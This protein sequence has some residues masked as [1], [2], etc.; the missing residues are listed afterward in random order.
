MTPVPAGRIA[1]VVTSLEMRQPPRPRPVPASELRLVR[2]PSPALDAYRTLFRRVGEPWLWFSRLIMPD[3]Q[4]AAIVGDARV[5]IHAVVDRRGIEVGML[6]LDFRKPGQCELAFFGL[7]PELAGR[8]H[9]RWLMTQALASAWRP[10][11]DR[12]WVHTCT[13]D[14]P[15]A[16]SFYR[17]QGF[18]AY[19]REV[20][21][22]DDPRLSG[23]LPRDAAPQ[24]P[25]IG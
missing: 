15:S 12:V 9:G 18:V 6:E 5:E 23:H 10:G 3:A 24:I 20:E 22:F 17:K 19:A 14:H 21:T 4:L 25:V 2:W 16:L 8:G 11:V 1:A 7:V 13:L